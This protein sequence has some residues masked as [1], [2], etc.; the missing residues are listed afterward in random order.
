[1]LPARCLSDGRGLGVPLF[2]G[3]KGAVGSPMR[4]GPCGGMEGGV[5]LLPSGSGLH[6]NV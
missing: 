6:S 5:I 2:M 1:V 3:W 4:P